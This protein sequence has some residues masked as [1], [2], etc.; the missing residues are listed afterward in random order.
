MQRDKAILS[1]KTSV[2]QQALERYPL[3]QGGKF[4]KYATLQGGIDNLL[5]NPMQSCE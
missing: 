5:I 1:G 2:L 3:I 4:N